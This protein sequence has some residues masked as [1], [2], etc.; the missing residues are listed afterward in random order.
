[1]TDHPF[2]AL[3]DRGKVPTSR[4]NLDT[5]IRQAQTRAGV[6]AGRFGWLVASTVVA[7]F[8]RTR[9][10]FDDFMRVLDATLAES[11]GA[12]ELQRT[13]VEPIE[14]ARR[15]VEPRRFEVKLLVDGRVWRSVDVEVAA[16]ERGAGARVDLFAGPLLGHFGLP[17]PVELAG[18]VFDYR[19]EGRLLRSL[20]L[21]SHRR[22][23][24]RTRRQDVAT[25][26]ACAQP[27]ACRLRGRCWRS[28]P[29]PDRRR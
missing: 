2:A 6:A 28:G 23:G 8:R 9:G 7:A 22:E 29:G 10:D 19:A 3:P 26:G 17:S 5:S 25:S 18:I 12:I 16:D 14:G 13:E 24:P 1:M 15:V 11:W 21:P 4:R 20:R 27:L